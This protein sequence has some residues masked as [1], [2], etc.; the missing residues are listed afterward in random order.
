[1]KRSDLHVHE[2]SPYGSSFGENRTDAE[3]AEDAETNRMTRRL[4]AVETDGPDP[5][6][7]EEIA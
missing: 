2:S 5:N 3:R 7:V 1:M 4:K 6:N